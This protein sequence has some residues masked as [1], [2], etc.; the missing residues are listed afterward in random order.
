M[1]A[2]DGPEEVKAAIEKRAAQRRRRRA[3][4]REKF[5]ELMDNADAGSASETGA[6]AAATPTTPTAAAAG[7]PRPRGAAASTPRRRGRWIRRR[8]AASI[9]HQIASIE[10]RPGVRVIGF[11]LLVGRV[12]RAV[13]TALGRR[14]GAEPRG[15]HRASP[16]RRRRASGRFSPRRR[17]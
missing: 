12:A 6:A 5:Q 7:A 15:R 1:D 16:I 8:C 11:A 17:A 9:F 10:D 3:T 4:E 14:R 2:A 13:V